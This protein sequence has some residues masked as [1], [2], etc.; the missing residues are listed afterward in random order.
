MDLRAMKRMEEP[1]ARVLVVDDDRSLREA[2]RDV[3][4]DD[5]YEGATAPHGAAALDVLRRCAPDVVVLDLRMPIMDGWAFLRFYRQRAGPQASV[6]VL[7]AVH[8][9]GKPA[10][11]E[12]EGVLQKPFEIADLLALVRQQLAARLASREA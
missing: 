11:L 9:P 12:A 10:G 2:I 1:G 7:T 6:I 5:G 3:L 4:L 8:S